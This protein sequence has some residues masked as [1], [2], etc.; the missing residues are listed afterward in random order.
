[1]AMNVASLKQC[2][3]VGK[4]KSG[5]LLIEDDQ[6]VYIIDQHAADERVQLEWICTGKSVLEATDIDKSMA[7]MSAIKLTDECDEGKICT[8]IS[9]LSDCTFPFICA[10]GRPTIITLMSK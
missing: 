2:V 4:F 1:M 9:R 8:I 6:G 5:F 10:H 7:C 3:F